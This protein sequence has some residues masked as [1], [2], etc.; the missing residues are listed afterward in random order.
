M[1][2][3]FVLGLVAVANAG[4]QEANDCS[5]VSSFHVAHDPALAVK[6]WPRSW[7]KRGRGGGKES[8]AGVVDGKNHYTYSLSPLS[9]CSRSPLKLP[10]TH[11]THP[12]PDLQPSLRGSRWK[13]QMRGHRYVSALQLCGYFVVVQRIFNA[14]ACLKPY[15][16]AGA[17]GGSC[18]QVGSFVS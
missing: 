10:R 13:R 4:F 1:R 12:T 14:P 16:V 9:S 6:F 3:I 8:N 17:T 7:R 18:G 2:S 5:S 15:R 11:I